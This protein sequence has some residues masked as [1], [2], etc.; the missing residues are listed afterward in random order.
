MRKVGEPTSDAGRA[1]TSSLA[2]PRPTKRGAA[3]R[4]ARARRRQ[5]FGYAKTAARYAGMSGVDTHSCVTTNPPRAV[6]STLA[7]ADAG[8][9]SR[10]SA[11]AAARAMNEA[12]V[13]TPALSRYSGE[14]A[15]KSTRNAAVNTTKRRVRR[16]PVLRVGKALDSTAG[17]LLSARRIQIN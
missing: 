1:T 11:N 9:L 14:A 8:T 17:R 2:M 4:S 5:L 10:R 16:P 15:M 12:S 3:A 6:D 7:V 13:R